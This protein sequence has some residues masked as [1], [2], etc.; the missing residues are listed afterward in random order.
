MSMKQFF[1]VDGGDFARTAA[2][3]LEAFGRVAM[4][5]DGACMVDQRASSEE[6]D[7]ELPQWDLG[8]TIPLPEQ[9]TPESIL[10]IVSKLRDLCR[11][12]EVEIVAR[13]VSPGGV[14]EACDGS[15]SSAST[16]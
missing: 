8:I 5:A 9:L 16:W 1:F 2:A 6:S 13:L 10:G 4:E 14:A 11:Q 15:S 3:L 12:Y 7:G